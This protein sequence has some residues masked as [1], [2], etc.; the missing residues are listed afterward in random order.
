MRLHQSTDIDEADARGLFESTSDAVPIH[1]NV[2]SGFPSR[3]MN[4]HFQG[5]V[6]SKNKCVRDK[7]PAEGMRYPLAASTGRDAYKGWPSTIHR[8]PLELIE[9]ARGMCSGL[10]VG[11][12]MSQ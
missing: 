1:L 2:C 6:I 10:F 5:E 7:L 4:R 12:A 8:A 9:K 11:G 3:L